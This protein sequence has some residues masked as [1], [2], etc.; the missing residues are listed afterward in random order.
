[1]QLVSIVTPTI[2]TPRTLRQGNEIILTSFGFSDVDEVSTPSACSNFKAAND[3]V[4]SFVE[5]HYIL[6][7][8]SIIATNI[9]TNLKYQNKC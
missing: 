1:M 5:A 3:I 4:V 9:N 2:R 6:F 7:L 8:N